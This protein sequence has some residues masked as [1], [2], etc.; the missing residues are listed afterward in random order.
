MDL[1]VGRLLG[2]LAQA[3]S[4]HSLCTFLFTFYLTCVNKLGSGLPS[5]RQ[6]GQAS[7][8]SPNFHPDVSIRSC[9]FWHEVLDDSWH[10]AGHTFPIPFRLVSRTSHNL[11]LRDQSFCL[12]FS[13]DETP[14]HLYICCIH[15]F[16]IFRLLQLQPSALLYF[17]A[18]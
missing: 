18:F 3:A 15:I 12:S 9:N 2:L 10:K 5:P 17:F 14:K 7:L 4:S 1:G 13:N 8:N 6:R 16:H 11:F